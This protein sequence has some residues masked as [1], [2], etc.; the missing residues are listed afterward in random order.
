[1]DEATHVCRW[2]GEG[3]ELRQGAEWG[4]L[5]ALLERP[6]TTRTFD[7]LST[8]GRVDI[9]GIRNVIAD[10]RVKL[11]RVDRGRDPIKNVRTIGYKLEDAG[12][13]MDAAS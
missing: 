7:E 2:Q 12:A 1:M 5:W 9:N 10:I 8:A 13:D 11:T 4:I 3:V 6:G